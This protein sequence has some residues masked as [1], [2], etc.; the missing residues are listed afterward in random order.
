[1]KTILIVEDIDLNIDLL[2]QLLEDEYALIVAKDGAQGV[3]LAEEKQPDLVIMDIALPIMDGYE[4]TRRIRAK[5]PSMPIVGLSS[6]AM[7]GDAERAMTAGCTD[8]LTKPI[9]EDQLLKTL[10]QHLG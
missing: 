2:S 7:S 8:Y 6:H 9:D 10:R 3:A 1:M 4:A 5:F